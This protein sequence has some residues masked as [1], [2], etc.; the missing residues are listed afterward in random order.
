MSSGTAAASN[1]SSPAPP[2]PPPAPK[3][4]DFPAAEGGKST[5]PDVSAL[6]SQLNKGADVTAGLKKVDKSQMVHK[7]PELRK[8]SVVPGKGDS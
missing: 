6:I 8:T 7:N 5:V 3:P 2:P 4:S 1:A